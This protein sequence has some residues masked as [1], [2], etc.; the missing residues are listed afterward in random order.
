MNRW[1]LAA[2]L[3]LVLALG[4]VPIDFPGGGGKAPFP[5]KGLTVVVFYDPS[6]DAAAALSPSQTEILNS[7]AAGSF[8][9]WCETNCDKAENGQPL[10]RA[11]NVR[12]V[13]MT[14][15]AEVWREAVKC[16]PPDMPLPCIAA[17][18]GRTGFVSPVPPTTTPAQVIETL[19]KLKG[20]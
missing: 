20:K 14:K 19:A 10:F 5:T 1:K 11:V 7:T 6:P 9:A 13:D 3:L 12:N 15:E 17:A 4:C 18:N 16:R 8:R 2:S